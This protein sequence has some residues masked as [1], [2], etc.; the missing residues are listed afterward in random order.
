MFSGSAYLSSHHKTCTSGDRLK[1]TILRRRLGQGERGGNIDSSSQRT[2]QTCLICYMHVIS[3]GINNR[4]AEFTGRELTFTALCWKTLKNSLGHH[5]RCHSNLH[6]TLPLLSPAHPGWWFPCRSVAHR[7]L[8][9]PGL[10]GPGAP[11][12][13]LHRAAF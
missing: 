12:P 3:I 13:H 1:S 4:L 11:L 6:L 9:A 10:A 5:Q 7:L 2:Q 8:P